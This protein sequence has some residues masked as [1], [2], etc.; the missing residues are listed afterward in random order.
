MSEAAKVSRQTFALTGV[1]PASP[2]LTQI[3]EKTAPR[4]IFRRD[5]ANFAASS[6]NVLGGDHVE[7]FARR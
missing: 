6:G 4:S 7:I 2:L 3:N 1:L 5:V